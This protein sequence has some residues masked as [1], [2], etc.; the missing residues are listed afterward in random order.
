MCFV[1]FA[2]RT[3]PRYPLVMATNRDEFYAR[4]TA[5]AAFWDD[6]PEVLAGCD[7]KAGGT[8]MGVTR[9]GRY[10]ALTNIREPESYRPDAPSRGAIV[11]TYLT[12]HEAPRAYL[13]RLR[14]GVGRYN[15]FNLLAGDLEEL[16]YFNNREG[17]V[18]ALAP[19]LYGLSNDRLDTPWPKVENGR[20]RLATLLHQDD[21]TPEAL[22]GLLADEQPAPASALP[23]TG[24]GAEW[25][26]ALSSIFI[27]TPA[28]GTR[29]ST[30]LL[31]DYEGRV[32]FVERTHAPGEEP[33]T[34][35][36]AFAAEP[37]P[38]P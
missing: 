34:R 1:V 14:A 23:D 2:Y 8:W 5:A 24:V 31:I 16:Y 36:Y 38:V 26:R 33:V 28:Y 22:L 19:G 30:L 27:R 20:Q 32:T 15:G 18:H 17:G 12:G 25:E 21:P 11:R 9:T 37:E 13:E 3:H 10:A 7:L 6:H 4:P 29:A 35:R